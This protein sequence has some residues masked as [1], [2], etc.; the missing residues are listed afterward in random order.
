MTSLAQL[1]CFAS[2]AQN[3]GVGPAE[4]V[5]RSAHH[6]DYRAFMDIARKLMMVGY[7]QGDGLDLIDYGA[8]IPGQPKG[9]ELVLTRKGKALWRKISEV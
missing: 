6:P 2:V 9:R 7:R 5:G 1:E 4:I 3:P 8:P